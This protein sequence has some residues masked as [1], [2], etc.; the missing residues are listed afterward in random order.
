MWFANADTMAELSPEHREI[1]RAA[2]QAVQDAV[3]EGLET[4]ESTVVPCAAGARIVA[5]A[6][7]DVA[8]IVEAAQ[9]VIDEMASDPVTASFLERIA[10]L[11]AETAP[12]PFPASCDGGTPSDPRRHVSP[13][14]R[15]RPPSPTRTR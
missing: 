1:L 11:K 5:A 7:E 12:A 9:P 10:A 15:T 8:A 6:D 4:T 13:M 3:L 2:A 14:G